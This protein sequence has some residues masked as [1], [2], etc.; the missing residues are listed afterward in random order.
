[1]KVHSPPP[2]TEPLY[3]QGKVKE[4]E[5][6]EMMN[7]LYETNSMM[8][9]FYKM[10]GMD[11]MTAV[12]HPYLMGN[13]QNP[14]ISQGVTPFTQQRAELE[15][16][17]S[18]EEQPRSLFGFS[19]YPTPGAVPTQAELSSTPQQMSFHT[20]KDPGFLGTIQAEQNK[21]MAFS[22]NMP[23]NGIMNPFINTAGMTN[24]FMNRSGVNPYYA[25]T[26]LSDTMVGSPFNNFGAPHNSQGLLYR[27]SAMNPFLL[28][29]LGIGSP[30][31]N[32]GVSPRNPMNEPTNNHS[33]LHLI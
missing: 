26:G 33:D 23:I 22:N 5:L 30:N 13:Y 28:G 16:S 27:L 17:E 9:P 18:G 20:F 1:M 10:Y 11:P 8:S 19:G 29:N 24:P 2:S 14:F 12:M 6:F 15:D 25:I 32:S 4:K 7:P 21:G 31:M 3:D